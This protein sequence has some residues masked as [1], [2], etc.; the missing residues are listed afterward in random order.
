MF[1]VKHFTLET[2]FDKLFLLISRRVLY[3]KSEADDKN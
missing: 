2:G 1:H 3:G